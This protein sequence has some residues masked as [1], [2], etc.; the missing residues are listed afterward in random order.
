MAEGDKPINTENEKNEVRLVAIQI[1]Q[2]NK[3]IQHH[4]EAHITGEDEPKDLVN[5]ALTAIKALKKEEEEEK[6]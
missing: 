2:S 6:E 3:F 1:D 5:L 4:Y